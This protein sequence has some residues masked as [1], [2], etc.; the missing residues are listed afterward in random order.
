MP[1][2]WLLDLDRTL[3][4]AQ[5]FTDYCTALADLQA[6]LADLPDVEVPTTGWAKCTTGAMRT[7]F[8][9]AGTPRWQEASDLV[10]RHELLGA[11]RSIAMPHL[12][13]F[14]DRIAGAPRAIVTL[15]P[16]RAARR[17]LEK[18]GVT[19]D[20][21][22]ARRADLAPKPAPDQVLAALAA[23]GATPD[24]ALMIGDSTWDLAAARA[25]GVPFVGLTNG[26]TPHEFPAPTPTAENLLGVRT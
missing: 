2:V 25:A 15:C 13:E 10:E 19:A 1:R 16:E 3:I 18:H 6:W 8:A 14:L 23:L 12:H 4:D 20:V 5:S 21:L 24:E 22:V 9:L 17:M 26:R 11:E 7:L